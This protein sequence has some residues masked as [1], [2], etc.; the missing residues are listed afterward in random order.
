MVV[1]F[2]MSFVLITRSV[3]VALT[4]YYSYSL[5]PSDEVLEQGRNRSLLEL[6]SSIDLFNDPFP[7]LITLMID[8]NLVVFLSF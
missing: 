1:D 6:I 7:T 5:K 8:I 2:E 4:Y 3:V